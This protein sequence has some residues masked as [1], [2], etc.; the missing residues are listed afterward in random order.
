VLKRVRRWGKEF[1][2]QVQPGLF[3]WYVRA[4]HGFLEPEMALLPRLCLPDR[5][6]VDIGANFGVYSYQMLR[7]S[8]ECIAFEPYPRLASLLSR[9]LGERLTVHQV[10]LSDRSGTAT[11][12]ASFAQTGHN[13]IEP[14]NRLESKV[15]D[16]TGLETLEVQTRRL[17]DYHLGP[18]GFIKIDVEGHEPEVVAGASETLAMNRPALLIE[19]EEQHRAEGRQHLLSFLGNLDYRSFFLRGGALYPAE[20]FDPQRDQNPERPAEYVRNF[21]FL[22]RNRLDAFRAEIRDLPNSS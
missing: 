15:L 22:P 7:Y 5:V 14:S 1:L 13:T 3:W 10:A 12:Q 4:R 21:I 19:I 20:T 11:M 2:L 8:K 16:P 17:D 6:S 18:V 9:G